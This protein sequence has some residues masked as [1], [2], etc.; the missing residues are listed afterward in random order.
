M[1]FEEPVTVSLG[2]SAAPPMIVTDARKKFL[3]S[4][5]TRQRSDPV[6]IGKHPIYL[7][8]SDR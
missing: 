3:H 7:P 6:S 5:L 2:M 1:T 4:S 8:R